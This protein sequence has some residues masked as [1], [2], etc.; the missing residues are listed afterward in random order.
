[1]KKISL[2]M[3]LICLSIGGW[4][5]IRL[6]ALQ[7][8]LLPQANESS[9]IRTMKQDL[10]CLMMAYP[11]Y[12]TGIE[13]GDNKG[14]YIVMKSGKKILYDDRQ[15]KS[16]QE[17]LANPDLQDMMEVIYP[18]EQITRL[19]PENYDPGRIRVYPLLYEIYG[20]SKTEIEQNLR[21]VKSGYRYYPFNHQNGAAAALELLM[22]ELVPLSEKRPDIYP[23]VFP[24]NGTF[25]YRQIAGTGQLSPHSFGIAI[26]L[27][28]DNK[29]YWKWVSREEGQKRLDSYPLEVVE[30]FEKHNFIWGGKWAHFDILHFEY[31][32]EIILKARY[33]SEKKDFNSPWY[34]GI[35]AIEDRV[36]D[37]I[38]MLDRV[39]E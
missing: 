15:E 24:M 39:L 38:Q 16:Y 5:S 19:M 36:K 14:V 22:E 7:S 30:I 8:F 25:N 18:L 13:I 37:Y 17:K 28:R 27:A 32:P 3:L 33:F 6:D 1:M 34:E 9:Y 2:Y 20:S 11:G 35:T 21:N 23:F 12:I 29:D 26:D 31:R 4:V 10:L